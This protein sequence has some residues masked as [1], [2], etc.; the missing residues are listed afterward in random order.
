M[1]IRLDNADAG[2]S[3]LCINGA[4]VAYDSAVLPSGQIT[5]PLATTNFTDPVASRNAK[6][7]ALNFT[8]ASGTGTLG[9]NFVVLDPMEPS[10]GTT[11]VSTGTPPAVINLSLNPTGLLSAPNTVRFVI[12]NGRASVWTNNVFADL[13]PMNVPMFWQVQLAATSSVSV[14]G[15]YEMKR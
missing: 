10:N 13:G 9:I 15:T 8:L 7:L 4:G 1:N 12:V 11:G 6:E 14:I 3:Y 5:G 2:F